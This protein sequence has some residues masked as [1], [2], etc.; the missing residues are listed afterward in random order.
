[1]KIIKKV[2]IKQIITEKS[3]QKLLHNFE[4]QKMQLEQE[5]QQL[6]FEQ[7]K[8]QNKPSLSKQEIETRFQQEIK[9]RRDKMMLI[10]F[11]V[12]QLDV[13]EIGSEVIESTVESL[14]EVSEGMHWTKVM[15]EQAIIIK[16]DRVIRIDNE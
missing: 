9:K 10:D 7:R 13:V 6:Q 3:K 2:L 1:M 8:L 5:C 15:D 4:T 16:D 12:E 11:K 14:V